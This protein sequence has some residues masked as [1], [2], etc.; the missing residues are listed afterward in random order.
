MITVV[1]M[2]VIAVYMFIRFMKKKR[3]TTEELIAEIAD[4]EDEFEKV[5]GTSWQT[6][7]TVKRDLS[8]DDHEFMLA[9]TSV[10]N[11]MYHSIQRYYV[12]RGGKK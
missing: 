11:S 4:F 2:I 8:K 1:F 9:V 10:F 7:I 3:V 12:E 6:W 5:Y